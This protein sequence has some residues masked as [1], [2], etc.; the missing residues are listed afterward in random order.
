MSLHVALQ[1][2]DMGEGPAAHF[3]IVL[4]FS[5]VQPL[6]LFQTK[7]RGVLLRAERT[8]VQFLRNRIRVCQGVLIQGEFVMEPSAT[9]WAF[10]SLSVG[11]N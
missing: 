11:M 4:A 1:C 8:G 3:T 2:L 9:C 6:V 5:V 10:E 7:L